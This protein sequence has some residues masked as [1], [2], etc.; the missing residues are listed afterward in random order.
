MNSSMIIKAV[1]VVLLGIVAVH[2]QG[3]PWGLVT[4]AGIAC[5]VLP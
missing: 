5:V 4:I 1:G 2:I 3:I